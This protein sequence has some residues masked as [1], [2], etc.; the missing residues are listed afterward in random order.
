V[1]GRCHDGAMEF[2]GHILGASFAS[3]DRIVVGRWLRSPFG[4]FA[5]VMWCGPHGRRVLLAPD[6]RVRDFLAGHYAFD[7]LHVDRVTAERTGTGAI[8]VSAGPVRLTVRPSGPGWASRLL[9]LRPQGLRT[10]RAWIDLEDRVLRPLVRPL[11]AAAHV[12]T[13]GVTLAGA[14][15]RYAIHDFRHAEANA[16]VDG[17]DLGPTAPCAAAGFGFSEFPTTPAVVRVTSMFEGV[18]ETEAVSGGPRGR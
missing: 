12:R 4:P 2:D 11:F 5:D 17:V 18:A 1:G 3:G 7:E 16:S 15:E 6:G 8:G 10:A 14:R 13:S 9:A